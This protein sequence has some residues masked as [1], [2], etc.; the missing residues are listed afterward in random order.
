M[1]KYDIIIIKLLKVEVKNERNQI[2][3]KSNF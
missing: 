2:F 1:K 3:I